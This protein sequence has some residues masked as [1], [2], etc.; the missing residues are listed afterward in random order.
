MDYFLFCAY[1]VFYR[2]TDFCFMGIPMKQ[3]SWLY[4]RFSRKLGG[5]RPIRGKSPFLGGVAI[6][7]ERSQEGCLESIQ[8]TYPYIAH[9]CSEKDARLLDFLCGDEYH[10]QEWFFNF[11]QARE[12]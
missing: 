12:I 10:W 11:T 1:S 9:W 7:N 2:S 4:L 3:K 8:K 5:A 6:N